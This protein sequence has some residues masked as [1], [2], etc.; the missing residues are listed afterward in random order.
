MFEISVYSCNQEQF[1]SRVTANAE[2]V[3]ATVP[4]Y[5]NGFWQA[6]LKHEIQRHS[7]PVRYN[8]LIGC[9]EVHTIGSQLRADYWFTDKKRILIGSQQKGV[10]K[11]RGKLLEKHYSQSKLSST[12]IFSDFRIALTTAI[13]DNTKLKNRFIDLS[14][15]NRCG[16]FI[17]WCALLQIST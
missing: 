4:D 13:G 2:K 16:P 10:V 11:W 7:K 9:I 14:A 1:I 12:D 5:K 15:F 8:E 6:Q 3:M 17:D